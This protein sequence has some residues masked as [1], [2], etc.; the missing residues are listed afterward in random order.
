L[1]KLDEYERNPK[2]IQLSKTLSAHQKNI[3]SQT[4]TESRLVTEDS[5]KISGETALPP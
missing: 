3:F 5:L 1:W 4:V 2:A